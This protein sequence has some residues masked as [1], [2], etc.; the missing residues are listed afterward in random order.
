MLHSFIFNFKKHRRVFDTVGFDGPPTEILNRFTTWQ[1]RVADRPVSVGLGNANNIVGA[2]LRVRP[3]ACPP[4]SVS[5]ALISYQQKLTGRPT[6]WFQLNNKRLQVVRCRQ[7]CRGSG[8]KYWRRHKPYFLFSNLSNPGKHPTKA[9]QSDIPK[10]IERTMRR[11]AQSLSMEILK[12]RSFFVVQI[13]SKKLRHRLLRDLPLP[14]GF[15]FALFWTFDRGRFSHTPFVPWV[16]RSNRLFGVVLAFARD[17]LPR[18][19]HVYRRWGF[20]R[21][22][23]LWR[24]PNFEI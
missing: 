22:R 17:H 5:D 10:K 24:I 13:T 23:F 19:I 4:S 20:D 9:A 11:K 14:S 18:V 1:C 2:D 3:F 15:A 8:F 6:M 12:K 21:G 7:V 16:V